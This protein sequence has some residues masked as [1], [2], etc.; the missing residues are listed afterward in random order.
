MPIGRMVGPLSDGRGR[1]FFDGGL[2]L[3]LNEADRG[4]AF[5]LNE[6]VDVLHAARSCLLWAI[7]FLDRQRLDTRRSPRST[8]L[9]VESHRKRK[10]RR[11]RERELR[12][13]A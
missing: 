1:E 7:A 10:S 12:L 4:A 6:D 2:Q 9:I 3:G 13:H 5:A 11:S 8:S